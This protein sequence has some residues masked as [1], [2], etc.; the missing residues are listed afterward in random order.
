MLI[1]ERQFRESIR[2][3]AQRRG[4][5]K[6]HVHV[7]NLTAEPYTDR[8]ENKR[9]YKVYR[10]AADLVSENKAGKIKAYVHENNPVI[11]HS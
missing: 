5:R 2:R 10:V 3:T 9:R 11:K 4:L 8:Q 7:R 6:Q 1:E